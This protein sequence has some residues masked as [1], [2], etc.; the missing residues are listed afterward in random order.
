MK[1]P[2]NGGAFVI[3]KKKGKI[4]DWKIEADRLKQKGLNN[5]DIAI[6]MQSY[7]PELNLLQI[8]EKIRGRF[9]VRNS[10]NR[11][12]LVFGDIHAPFTHPNYLKFIQDVAKLRGIGQ[13]VCTGDLVDYHALS[14]HQTETCA[15][16]PYDELDQAQIIVSQ[17]VE[18]FPKLKLCSGNHDFI[19]ERQAATLGI[20]SRYLKSFSE[21]FNLPKEWE[22]QDEFL[23][24]DVLYKHGM[25]CCGKNGALNDAILGRVSTVIGHAHAFGGVNYS[26][27]KRNI[28][29]GMNVGCGVDI[30]AYAF[31]YG[32]HS[33]NRETLGCGIVYNASH[34]EFV[35]MSEKFFRSNQNE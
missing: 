23:I 15:K 28:I 24:D 6:E 30:D 20:G 2:L 25:N 27:N 18:A 33:K 4:M 34:A 19:L 29:F 31:A 32:K 9:R 12:T 11:P 3:P 8:K 22:I 26:A 1:A 13:V 10:I 5:T 17:Y 35:P 7:F 16:S 21:L 14:R